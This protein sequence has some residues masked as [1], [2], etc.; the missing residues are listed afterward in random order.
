MTNLRNLIGLFLVFTLFFTACKKETLT[1]ESTEITSPAT[2]T[3]T[4][5]DVATQT[6]AMAAVASMAQSRNGDNLDTLD[7]DCGCFAL[8]DGIDLDADY[9]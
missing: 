1:P 3:P 4:T 7:N 9:E 6:R 8:F 5:V 2:T